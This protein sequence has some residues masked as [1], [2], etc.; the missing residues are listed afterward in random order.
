[1]PSTQAQRSETYRQR[2]LRNGYKQIAVFVPE[3]IIAKLDT[4]PGSRS[5]AVEAVVRGSRLPDLMVRLESIQKH[6]REV[7]M[8]FGEKEGRIALDNAREQLAEL[9]GRLST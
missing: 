6:L 3:E 9:R 5:D 4:L 8:Q 7:S 2:R 1:M